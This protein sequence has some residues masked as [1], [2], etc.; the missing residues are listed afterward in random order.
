MIK[1]KN[2]ENCE[3]NYV[4]EEFNKTWNIFVPIKMNREFMNLLQLRHLD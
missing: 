2:K 1:L 3:E 4:I